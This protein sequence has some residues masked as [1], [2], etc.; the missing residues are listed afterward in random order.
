MIKSHL[1]TSYLVKFSNRLANTSKYFTDYFDTINRIKSGHKLA[2]I[3]FK[4]CKHLLLFMIFRLIYCNF[5]QKTSHFENVIHFNIFVIEK[6]PSYFYILAILFLYMTIFI[7]RLIYLQNNGFS[8]VLI[9]QLIENDNCNFFLYHHLNLKENYLLKNLKVHCKSSINEIKISTFLRNGGV[10]MKNFTDVIFLYS[11]S[12]S[13]SFVYKK[14][15]HFF[16]IKSTDIHYFRLYLCLLSTF[17]TSKM[18]HL[19]YFILYQL[20]SLHFFLTIY[21]IYRILNIAMILGVLLAAVTYVKFKQVEQYVCSLKISNFSFI[22]FSILSYHMNLSLKLLAD[23]NH[24]YGI[25]L[26]ILMLVNLPINALILMLLFMGK[27]N[28]S[29]L[30]L[31]VIIAFFQ[32]FFISIVNFCC[33]V[34]SL[35][36]YHPAKRFLSLSYR[37]QEKKCFL[38]L[39]T[40]LKMAFFIQLFYV[41]NQFTFNF[42]KYSKITFK[43]VGRSLFYYIKI[44]IFA[45]R[46]VNQAHFS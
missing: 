41:K 16:K 44:L 32:T 25:A 23:M 21:T 36:F 13:K 45:Y 24:I 3:H 38:P 5:K 26:L 22:S 43:N 20:N 39:K 12:K 2:I 11:L 18:S 30:V 31:A 42:G 9:Q 7:F 17:D 40:K 15:N 33:A 14:I 27:L 46:L 6:F 1:K 10:L 34:L 19:F 28:P 37:L 8:R 29:L 35:R 4:L